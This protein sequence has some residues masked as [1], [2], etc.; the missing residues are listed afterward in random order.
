MLFTF[1]ELAADH[2]RLRNE[3]DALVAEYDLALATVTSGPVR[4]AAYRSRL[5][6]LIEA[7]KRHRAQLA[8]FR[9]FKCEP[10]AAAQIQ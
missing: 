6:N 10:A 2:Q 9:A 3:M 7:L 5:T 1:Q 4:C 8:A